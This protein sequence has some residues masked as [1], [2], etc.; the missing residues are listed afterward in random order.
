MIL[1]AVGGLWVLYFS[2]GLVALDTM[3]FW[4]GTALIFIIATTQIIVFAWVMGMD[5][6]MAEAHIGAKMRIPKAYRFIIKY[7]APVYLLIVFTGFCIQDLPG[8]LSGLATN[9]VA[10]YTV[11]FIGLNLLILLV[12]T[13][14]AV[15]RWKAAGVDL[16]GQLPDDTEGERP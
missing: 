4:V 6:G 5:R 14:L 10:R 3:N 9:D 11:Y 16:D 12:I 13:G 1:T 2:Q 15:R 8:Y 7:V